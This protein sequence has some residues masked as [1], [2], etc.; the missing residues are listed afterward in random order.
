MKNKNPYLIPFI[1]LTSLFFLWG[2]AHSILDV[3][4]KHFQEVLVIS[5]TRSAL[6]Q[7]VVYGG[8][9]LMALPA[10]LFIK[11][12]GYR[13]GVVFG[14]LLYGIGALLFIPAGK[15]MSFNFFLFSLFVI[16]CGLTFLETAANPYVTEL[17]DKDT[18]SGRLNLAQSFNGLGW[19]IGPLVGGMLIFQAD[20]SH[21]NI[22]LPYTMIGF[23]VLAVAFIFMRIKLPVISYE[24]NATQQVVSASL[25]KNKL[26]VFGVIAQ[27]F[28]VGAQTGIN[29]FFINYV[30]ELNPGI[31]SRNAA[32]ILSFAGMGLFM[33]GRFLGSWLMNRYPAPKLLTIAAAGAFLC[34]L[35]VVAA[36]PNLSLAALITTYLFE[37]IM[38]PTIF[39]LSISGL[40]DQTKKGSSFLIMSIVGGAIAPV[41]M[42]WI[43]ET[44]MSLGFFVPMVSFVIIFL[45]SRYFSKKSVVAVVS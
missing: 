28:Y 18:A 31:N 32:F 39:A 30:T 45:F 37:S 41:L 13:G 5:K 11:R 20:G 4:N 15:I 26:F 8:Y 40:G 25:W 10:G 27:F 7:T 19:I 21:G 2:F 33:T 17:G 42:G 16:G 38:F 29:S 44:N 22:A 3:L 36:I 6:V 34:M 43:G 35:I 1:L 9:F 14:L 24:T 12:F 23:V